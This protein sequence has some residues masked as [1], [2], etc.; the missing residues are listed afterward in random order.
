VLSSYI[1]LGSNLGEPIALLAAA[2]AA[3][4]RIPDTRL[5]ARSSLYRSAPVGVPAQPDFVNAVARVETG[6]PPGALLDALQAIERALGRERPFPGAPRTLDLDLL[7][8]GSQR[9][10]TGRLTVPHPRMHERAFVLLPLLELDPDAQIPDR[11][12][13]RECLGS[14]SGQCVERIG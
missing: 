14:V 4:S 2:F 10:A 3:L 7:L 12:A 9:I 13:A 5:A 6:L 1:G 11:G 8:Y